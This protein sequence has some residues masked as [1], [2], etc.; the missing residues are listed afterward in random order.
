MF[1]PFFV[2]RELRQRA[3][4]AAIRESQRL[5]LQIYSGDVVIGTN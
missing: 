2:L 3:R 4:M 5:D 1:P